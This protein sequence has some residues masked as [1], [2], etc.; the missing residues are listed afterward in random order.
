MTQWPSIN[1]LRKTK[2][3]ITGFWEQGESW[4]TYRTLLQKGI[5]NPAIARGYLP[6]ITKAAELA[7]KAMPRESPCPLAPSCTGTY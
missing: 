7:S 4:R 3:N 2:S 5:M 1:F 6:A